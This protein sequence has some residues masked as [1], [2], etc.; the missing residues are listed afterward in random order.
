VLAWPN[1]LSLE[2]K[3]HSV[4]LALFYPSG[5]VDKACL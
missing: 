3:I 1:V 2:L 5:K 4:L